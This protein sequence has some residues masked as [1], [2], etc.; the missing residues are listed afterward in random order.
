MIHGYTMEECQQLVDEISQRI[1]IPDYVI[2][3]ST[4]EFKKTRIIYQT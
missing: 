2:L 3:F 1:S 4:K